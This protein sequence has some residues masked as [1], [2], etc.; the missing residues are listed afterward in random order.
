MRR[1]PF[2]LALAVAVI[3]VALVARDYLRTPPAPTATKSETTRPATAT[4][5]TTETKPGTITQAAKPQPQPP[6]EQKPEEKPT[7]TAEKPSPP[8]PPTTEEV[9]A[10]AD[11]LVK[12]GKL[13]EAQKTLSKALLANPDDPKAPEIKARLVK[14]ADELYFSPKPSPVSVTYTVVAGDSLGKIARKHKTTVG[15]IKRINRL[16]GDT[17]RVGQRLKIV[18]GGFD[19]E[20]VK[21]KFL[22]T[23]FKDGVWVREFR[24]GLGKDGSTPVGEFVAGEKLTNPTY[25]GNGTPIPFGDKKNNPLGTRW[26]TIQG[27]YGIHGTWEPDSIGKERSKGCV[28]MRNED[29]EWLFD[30][31]VRGESKIVIKR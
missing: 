18:P 13:V 3:V 29:V 8:K 9:L 21:S 27:Q 31:V 2:V 12:A 17:I 11:E 22:L 14:L 25:F 24:V 20:V 19:I 1:W 26:I 23:V 28:R 7:E 30:L 15:L 5:P 6:K 4:K 10:K 16:K